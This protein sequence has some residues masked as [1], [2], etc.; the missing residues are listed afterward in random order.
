[1]DLEIKSFLTLL[2]S[3][4]ID[5]ILIKRRLNMLKNKIGNDNLKIIIHGDKELQIGNKTYYLISKYN[6]WCFKSQLE[7]EIFVKQK[8]NF[9]E[10]YQIIK[11]L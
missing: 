7:Y 9:N 6:Q 5:N 2:R 1:M 11:S 3:D 4:K 10:I 8:T